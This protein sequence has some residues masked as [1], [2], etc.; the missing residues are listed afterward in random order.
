MMILSIGVTVKLLTSWGVMKMNCLWT[1]AEAHWTRVS[2]AILRATA[3]IKT[4]NSSITRKG[5][6]RFSPRARRRERVVKVPRGGRGGERV[7]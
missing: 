1:I 4:S 2:R 3:S 6:S 5:V 7:R